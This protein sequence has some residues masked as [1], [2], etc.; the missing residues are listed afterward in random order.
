MQTYAS[1]F[2][3]AESPI[4]ASRA[5]KRPAKGW[6]SEITAGNLLSRSD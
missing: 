5:A 1:Q 6:A 2:L 4:Y 3:P